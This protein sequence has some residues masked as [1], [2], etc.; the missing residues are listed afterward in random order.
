MFRR[1]FSYQVL[2]MVCRCTYL[3]HYARNSLL[4]IFS[5]NTLVCLA[6]FNGAFSVASGNSFF[7]LL[8]LNSFMSICSINS[9]FAVGCVQESFKICHG[10]SLLLM[11][12]GIVYALS[13]ICVVIF[14][15]KKYAHRQDLPH[16]TASLLTNNN[17]V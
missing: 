5:V 1:N 7:S 9:V 14:L 17:K 10:S 6:V 4:S 2:D 11:L 12:G 13:L 3:S 15:G 16:A 8:S